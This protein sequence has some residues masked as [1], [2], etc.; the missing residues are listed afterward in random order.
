MLG[1]RVQNQ[2]VF[3]HKSNLKSH[4]AQSV[5]ITGK[6]IEARPLKSLNLLKLS[7]ESSEVQ[8]LALAG[9]VTYEL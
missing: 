8:L 9:P 7:L 3:K 1:V 5:S 2:I 6:C 4:W